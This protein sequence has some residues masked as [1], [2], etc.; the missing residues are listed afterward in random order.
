M[1]NLSLTTEFKAVV[2]RIF[3]SSES[4]LND[5]PP[6]DHE[7]IKGIVEKH[8][9][10]K[11]PVRIIS[12]IC[13][14]FESIGDQQLLKSDMREPVASL[15]LE[16]IKEDRSATAVWAVSSMESDLIASLMHSRWTP[17]EIDSFVEA[18]L[19]TLECLCARDVVLDTNRYTRFAGQDSVDVNSLKKAIAHQGRLVTYWRLDT[20]GFNLIHQGLHTGVGN[21]IDL[22]VDL[23]PEQLEDV[24]E[25]LDH[26]AVQARAARRC[27]DAIR[28]SDHR[29]SLQWIAGNSC[30]ALISLAIL[31]T[32]NTVNL[33]DHEFRLTDRVDEDWYIRST[34]LRHPEAD[35]DV[36]ATELLT[37]LV[38]RLSVLDPLACARWIG[39]LLCHVPNVLRSHDH[40]GIPR[41][42]EQLEMACTQILTRLI[43]HALS[44]EVIAELQ[45][46]LCCTTSPTWTRHLAA[47]AWELRDVDPARAAEIARATLDEHERHVTAE[48]EA[49]HFFLHLND[50]RYRDWIRSLG[51]A[52]ALSGDDLDLPS[53]VSAQCG[54]LPLSVWD[55]EENNEQFIAADRAV[56]HWFLIALDAVQCLTALGRVVDSAEVRTLAETLWT[57][58]HFADKYLHGYAGGS[59]VEE[60]AARLAIE[61]GKADDSWLLN[62]ARRPGVGARALWGLMD[63]RKLHDSRNRETDTH[64]VEAIADEFVRVAS[65]RFSSG[66]E[67]DLETLSYWGR[68]WLGLRAAKEA[69][70]T[71]MAIMAFH[72]RNQD[73]AYKI[74]ALKLLAFAA[75][76][77]ETSATVEDGIALLYGQIWPGST[78]AE[79][80]A[81]RQEIDDFLQRAS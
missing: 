71:A 64:Y 13:T 23:R 24:I 56:Q 58:C 75:R 11:D 9:P 10:S 61:V 79:E 60:Y 68:L 74:V 16:G 69:E 21:L 70:R 33:L 3:G 78:P 66:E 2:W 54:K 44:G 77:G 57:H 1:T 59:D 40:H 50:W 7:L 72:L 28:R 5:R 32:L 38:H 6:Y 17:E 22:M 80:R 29:K 81:A 34:E 26:P 14:W 46:G 51:A 62:Q 48:M 47:V 52:L 76:N 37:D 53:W 27:I 4:P 15:I 65:N 43:R 35:L 8:A 41:R 63:Q 67:F 36:A 49:K 12:E 31:H 55:A 73:R 30:D 19:V 42:I 18:A 45:A 25:R 20:H 39:E